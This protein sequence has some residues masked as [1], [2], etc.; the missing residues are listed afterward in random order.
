[1]NPLPTNRPTKEAPRCFAIC[2]DHRKN[3]DDLVAHCCGCGHP[4]FFSP[5]FAEAA[6][7]DL[8]EAGITEE[9][10]KICLRCFVKGTLDAGGFAA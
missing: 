6:R 8:T 10:R 2:W 1:M 7:P 5:D 4:V 3:R 9:P